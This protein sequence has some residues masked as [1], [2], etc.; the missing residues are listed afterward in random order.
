MG[1]TSK[2]SS[3]T[4]SHSSIQLV[5]PSSSNFRQLA[6]ATYYAPA[7]DWDGSDAPLGFAQ[8]KT[9]EEVS[10][11]VRWARDA[12]VPLSVR[13]GGHEPWGRSTPADALVVDLKALNSIKVISELES[14]AATDIK[15][16]GVV[17]IGGGVLGGDLV[18]KLAEQ[19]YMVPCAAAESVGHTSWA[20]LGGYSNMMGALGAGVDQIEGAKVVLA[21]GEVVDVGKDHE[22]LF[23]IRGAGGNFGIIVE[24]RIR[25]YR[26]R[27]VSGPR[28]FHEHEAWLLRW[29]SES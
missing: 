23:G 15:P 7:P 13:V 19:G 12:N 20:C 5:T 14:P 8:P 29:S 24:L 1:S 10:Q 26:L 25:V 9:T 4:E 16:V 22:L 11:I 21:D 28:P 3:L 27:K 17:A 18:S 6:S 2:L